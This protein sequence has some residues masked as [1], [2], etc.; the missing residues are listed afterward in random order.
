[1][2]PAFYTTFPAGWGVLAKSTAGRLRRAGLK[3]GMPDLQVFYKGRTIGIELK[4]G[5]N[6]LTHFQRDTHELLRA[7]GIQVFVCT[8]L[9]EVIEV[10]QEL[11]FP[12]R[13]TR[14]A[15]DEQRKSA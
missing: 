11:G 9:D 5:R 15:S 8:C 3:R 13:R 4:V 1:M 10:L 14:G 6:V 12:L 7:A 2:P